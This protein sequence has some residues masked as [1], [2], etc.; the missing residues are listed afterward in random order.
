M[1]ILVPT[2]AQ[3]DVGPGYIWQ[4]FWE[5]LGAETSMEIVLI[6][7]LV[8]MVALRI[9]MIAVVVVVVALLKV[10]VLELGEGHLW[11][12]G[13]RLAEVRVRRDG[14]LLWLEGKFKISSTGN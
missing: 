3:R 4:M 12:A 7:L 14:R 9:A 5:T 13:L 1:V 6:A 2:R 10:G 11:R 8:A